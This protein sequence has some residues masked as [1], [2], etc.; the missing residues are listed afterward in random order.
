[1]AGFRGKE[2]ALVF[3][4]GYQ[5]NTGTI[6]A[7]ASKGDAIF[8]DRL[9]HASIIDG[10]VLSG[11]RFFRYRHNDMDHL[12]ELLRTHRRKYDGALVITESVFSM[13]GDIAPV[14]DIISLKEEFDVMVM[15]DEAHATGVFGGKG[16]G[17]VTGRLAE[18]CDVI[19]G[20]FGKAFGVFGAYIASSRTIK[21]YLVNSARSFIYSTALPPAVIN[22]DLAALEMVEK[23]DHRR[24]ELHEN[25]AFF[26]QKLKER[27]VVCLGETQIVPVV[28]GDA[29]KASRVSGELR[30][31]GW[32]VT[33]VRPPT[34]PAGSSRL[35]ISITYDH[36][37]DLLEKLA[38]DI[39][40][41]AGCE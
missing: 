7:L 27:G 41:T 3:N 11:A 1:V 4:S 12:R 21:E 22:A 31:K 34:V 33:P 29:A 19:M 8:A 38:E 23:E 32:L 6:S 26:R 15:I 13:E 40:A 25:V 14:E 5:A 36:K 39:S 20:T 2:A 18:K 10:M 24:K 35:R 9:C 30:D 17:L 28:L 16:E 37:K